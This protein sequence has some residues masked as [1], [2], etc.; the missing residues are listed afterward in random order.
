[1]ARGDHIYVCRDTFKG[2]RVGCTLYT[3]HAIDAGDGTVIEYVSHTDAKRDSVIVRRQFDNF[4]RGGRV[5]IRQYGQRF[6]AETTARRAESMLGTAGYEFFTNNCEHFATW[7]VTGQPSSAQIENGVTGAGLATT[8]AVA[9]AVGVELVGNFGT[10]AVRSGP[11]VMSGLSGI[12]GSAVGGIAV[13]G[14]ASGLIAT[15]I[16][17]RALADK[18]TLPTAQRDARRAGR[19]AALGGAVVGTG[20]AVYAVGAMG[21]PGFSGAG[22][23]SGLA[24]LGSLTGGGMVRGLSTTVLIPALFAVLLGYMLYRNTLRRRTTLPPGQTAAAWG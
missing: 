10:A 15:G 7:C 21:V 6:D 5:A 18:P 2:V 24:A 8:T 11:N 16:M 20:A 4:A 19:Q 13:L 9:P 3:H 12:G 14:G 1:M 17:C 23:S 22:I